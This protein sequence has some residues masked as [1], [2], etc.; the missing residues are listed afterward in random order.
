[1]TLQERAAVPQRSDQRGFTLIELLVTMSIIGILSAIAVQ[2]LLAYQRRAKDARA[3]TLVRVVMTAEEAYYTD[4][5]N[6][7]ACAGG[8]CQV[9][10]SGVPVSPG[11]TV[12]VTTRGGDQIFDVVGRH[13]SGS[14]EFHYSSDSGHLTSVSITS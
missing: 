7:L 3:E 1:M 10:L 6:Y 11:V 9:T 14:A 8:D 4:N 2:G 5:S 12:T 13:D